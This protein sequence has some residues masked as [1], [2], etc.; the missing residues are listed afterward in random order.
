MIRRVRNRLGYVVLGA[1]VVV[2]AWL[3]IGASILSLPAP[4]A[5]DDSGP[6]MLQ[7]IRDLDRYVP[8]QGTFEVTVVLR[9]GYP[10]VP[11]WVYGYEGVL[12]AH[13][14]VDAYVDLSGLPADAITVSADRT[15]VQVELPAPRLGPPTVDH[16]QSQVIDSDTGIVNGVAEAFD[17]R[18]DR[19]Q[20]LYRAAETKLVAA[21]DASDLRA[22]AER[23][24][25]DAMRSMGLALGFE[26]VEVTF[27]P[28]T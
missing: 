3:G 12:V 5:A 26:T 16:R 14:T 2:A 19:T 23:N 22:R 21:A 10:R 1:A 28:I 4:E 24:T 15:V 25:A 11:T 27:R 17:G 20:E 18:T 9:E 7:S 6:V 13:G 8:A